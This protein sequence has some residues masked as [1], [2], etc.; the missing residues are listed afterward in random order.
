[1]TSNYVVMIVTLVIWVGVFLYL[2]RLDAK[3]KK[4]EKK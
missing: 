4:L 1:M 3:V 2:L